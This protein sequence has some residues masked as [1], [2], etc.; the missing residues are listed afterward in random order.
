[1]E[2]REKAGL[3]ETIIGEDTIYIKDGHKQVK[4]KR[5]EILYLE[6]LRDYTKIV[7]EDGNHYVLSSIGILLK[8]PNFAD[9]IRIHRSFAVQKMFVKIINTN[10]VILTNKMLL[11]IGRGFK[12]NISALLI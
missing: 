4:I 2:L 3:L 9:F 11:P 12:E 7:T 5:H 8:E 6:G 1:M 10:E